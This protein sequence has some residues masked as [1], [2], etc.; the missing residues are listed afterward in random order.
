MCNRFQYKTVRSTEL[1]NV[2]EEQRKKIDAKSAVSKSAD[3]SKS[4]SINKNYSSEEDVSN[5]FQ[6]LQNYDT[7]EPKDGYA[8]EEG[9]SFVIIL[10]LLSV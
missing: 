2:L 9:K 10:I 1:K 3:K 8:S 4:S 5:N 6:F 7:E